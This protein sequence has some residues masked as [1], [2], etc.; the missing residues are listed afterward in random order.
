MMEVA[1]LGGGHGCYAA[2]AHLSEEGHSV[3][4]WRQNATAFSTVLET[5]TII[6]TDWKGT[7]DVLIHNPTESVEEALDGAELIIIPLPS[8]THSSLSAM[9]APHF[10][11]GQ[12]VFLPPGTFGSIIFAQAI[13]ASGNKANVSFAE[14]GTLPYLARKQSERHVR[15]SVYATR[16][17]TGVFPAKDSTRALSV[18]SNAYP[19]TEPLNDVLNGA[20]MNAGPIIH[21]PLIIM[22]AGP[23][24]NFE[25]WDI[26]NEGTQSSIRR[27][28]DTLDNERIQLR[29]ALGYGKPHFPLSDHYD[30]DAEE[31]MYGDASHQKCV[32]SGDWREK[33]DLLTH[34]YMLED[35]EVG[36]S[37]LLSLGKWVGFEM[38]LTTGLISVASSIVGRD[39]YK[40]GR[41]LES[42]GL[43]DLTQDKFSQFLYRGVSS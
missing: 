6:L 41:T 1:V 29:E 3:R 37:F 26:H 38:P 11:D 13:D 10:K 20:L 30:D 36:L 9:L 28:T 7:R 19:A 33:I 22:N 2:A 34:R 14:T 4:M 31:W 16:L 15:I 25:S 12:I 43:E 5:K 23:L 21:P 18:I 27:V 24:E 17:P 35:V 42:L 39:L 8:T 40:F 32:D